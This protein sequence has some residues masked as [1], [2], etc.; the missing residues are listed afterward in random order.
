MR[1]CYDS[2]NTIIGKFSWADKNN[3]GIVNILDMADV[4][5][6]FGQ[7]DPYWN[8][9]QNPL[10]PNVGT[11]PAVVDIAAIATAAF[12]F[13]HAPF[14]NNQRLTSSTIT[15]LDPSINPS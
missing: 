5:F 4:A 14:N 6:H 13:G 12:Y 1:C 11:D 8:T 15:R 3:D 9:G 10:A 2:V 7:P